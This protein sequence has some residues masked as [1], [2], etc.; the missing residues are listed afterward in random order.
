MQIGLSR[1][2][3][4]LWLADIIE[5]RSGLVCFLGAGPGGGRG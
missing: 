2:R 5:G 1:W 4:T 3:L